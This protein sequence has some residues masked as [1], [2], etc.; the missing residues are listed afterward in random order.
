MKR[1][2]VRPSFVVGSLLIATCVAMGYSK[3]NGVKPPS[4]SP[5]T[6]GIVSISGQLAQD[7]ILW[8][9]DGVVPFSLTLTAADSVAD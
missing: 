9:G 8:G 1:S 6:T 7:K 5:G 2:Y 3:N 4:D